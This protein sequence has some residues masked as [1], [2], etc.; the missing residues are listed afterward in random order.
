MI[1]KFE[2]FTYSNLGY[3]PETPF[4]SKGIVLQQL[5]YSGTSQ[6]EHRCTV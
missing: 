4:Q 6:R 1:L 2:M 5:Y 3:L